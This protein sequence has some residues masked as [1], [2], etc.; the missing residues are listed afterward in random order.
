MAHSK[1][2]MASLYWSGFS[3]IEDCSQTV[4]VTPTWYSLRDVKARTAFY[5][6]DIKL[7]LKTLDA[8]NSPGILKHLSFSCTLKKIKMY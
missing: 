3:V 1:N 6:S 8:L 5:F 7:S 2:V 4:F